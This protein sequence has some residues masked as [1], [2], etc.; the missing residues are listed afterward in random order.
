MRKLKHIGA[1]VFAAVIERQR[2]GVGA[3]KLILFAAGRESR[4][5][6]FGKPPLKPKLHFPR[7]KIGNIS[8][9]RPA[10]ISLEISSFI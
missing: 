10:M 6:S 4:M 7:K 2:L 3:F 5:P 8:I 9:S 1:A